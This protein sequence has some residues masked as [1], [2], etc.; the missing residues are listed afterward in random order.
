MP[1]PKPTLARRSSVLGDLRIILLGSWGFLRQLVR[2][3]RLTPKLLDPPHDD[4]H[5]S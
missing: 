2:S 1:A 5:P 3:W 4:Q